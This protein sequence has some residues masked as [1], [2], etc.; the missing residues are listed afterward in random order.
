[1][2]AG[3]GLEVFVAFV[4]VG[5]LVGAV[6]AG[7]RLR[8]IPMPEVRGRRVSLPAR[9][10]EV[11]EL[12]QPTDADWRWL[13]DGLV[14][15][16]AARST[17]REVVTRIRERH[18]PGQDLEPVLIDELSAMFRGDPAFHL[19]EG[20]PA[21]VLVVA[22]GRGVAATTAGKLAHRLTKE[23]RSVGVAT[24]DPGRVKEIAQWAT[25][26]GAEPIDEG[27][28]GTRVAASVEAARTR[29]RDVLI[30]DV[31]RAPR[32]DP[33]V[34]R[35]AVE[36]TAGRP[37]DAVV[38]GLQAT[39]VTH[40]LPQ[41]RVLSDAVGATGLVLTDLDMATAPSAAAA[42]AREALGIP[43]WFL[44][45]GQAVDDLEPFEPRAYA[46]SLL[47]QVDNRA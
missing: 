46:A 6:F 9:V 26:A 4:L 34:V 30:L 33:A 15:A 7:R 27:Q 14:R 18:E 11:S 16:G 42:T 22:Q 19:P 38:L 32:Q 40:V 13:E 41:S 36:I 17:G 8:E 21:I 25:R 5:C 39:V 24:A 47:R 10:R 12:E 2:P 29:G 23:G 3:V 20:R 35:R 31:G 37:P 43:V 44:A 45:A 28:P 1:V